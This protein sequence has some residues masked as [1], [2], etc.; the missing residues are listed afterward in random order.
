M[1]YSSGIGE[2]RR[3]GYLRTSKGFGNLLNKEF[4]EVDGGAGRNQSEHI[5]KRIKGFDKRF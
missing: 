5:I 1:V 2:I 3:T 4:P